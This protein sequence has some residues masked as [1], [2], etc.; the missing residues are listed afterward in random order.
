MGQKGFYL[1]LTTCIG[2][3]TCQIACNDKNNLEA[4]TLFR[5]VHEFEGGEFPKP[6]AYTIS[7]SCNHCAHPKCVEN[8]PART[9]TKRADGLVVQD[10]DKCIGCR[11]CTWSCPYGAPKYIEKLGKV[12]KCNGCA[13]LVDKGQNPACV[14][15]CLMRALQFGELDELRQ[16]YGN[17]ADVKGLPDSQTTQP[18]L[19]LKQTKEAMK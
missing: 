3:K 11:L 5:Q 13:D 12:D 10:R 9:L 14:D 1:D 15:A 4:G 7:L 2:C 17:T 6:W 8:C 18:S 16:K 19:V